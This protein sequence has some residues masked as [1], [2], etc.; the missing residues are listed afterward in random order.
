MHAEPPVLAD[1]GDGDALQRIHVEHPGD[2]VT[3]TRGQVGGQR[4]DG[5]R[6]GSYVVERNRYS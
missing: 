3:G 1:L 6:I 4:V 5:Q 2:Q